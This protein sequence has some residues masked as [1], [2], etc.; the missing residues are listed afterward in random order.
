MLNKEKI[1]SIET[2]IEEI[3]T[4]SL[5]SVGLGVVKITYNSQTPRKASLQIM[6]ERLDDKP[7]QVNDCENASKTIGALL[8]VEDI[9][10]IPYYLEVGSS[11]L[12]RPLVKPAD[13]KRFM[14]QKV[15]IESK[16]LIQD[17]RTLKGVLG[18]SDE[19]KVNLQIGNETIEIAFEDIKSARLTVSDDLIN[20]KLKQSKKTKERK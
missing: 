9:I 20:E 19:N 15:K 13:F 16:I 3:V 7:L 14:G 8:D 10:K 11:G 18:S 2:K 1:L 12:D 17:S 4:P 6:L 5:T